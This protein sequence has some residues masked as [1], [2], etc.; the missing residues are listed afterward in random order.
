MLLRSSMENIIH[1]IDY[2]WF[3]IPLWAQFITLWLGLYLLFL[4]IKA[5]YSLFF[6][7]REGKE[8]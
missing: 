2:F 1:W 6:A 5:V 8:G 3:Y 7:S 4:I